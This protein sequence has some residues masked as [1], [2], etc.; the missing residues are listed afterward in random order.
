MVIGTS[1]KIRHSANGKLE[2]VETLR[3]LEVPITYQRTTISRTEFSAFPLYYSMRK[4]FLAKREVF[5]KTKTCN[6]RTLFIP[7]LSFSF[8]SW[9]SP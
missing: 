8:K 6:F 7:C 5:M 4:S 9:S 3:Y 1:K 2:E